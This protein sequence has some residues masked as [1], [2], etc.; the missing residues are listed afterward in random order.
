M[1]VGVKVR[2]KSGPKLYTYLAYGPINVGDKVVVGV[3]NAN[4][5]IAEVAEIVPVEDLPRYSYGRIVRR[6]VRG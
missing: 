3:R 2:F 5:V 4:K 1:E 6:I